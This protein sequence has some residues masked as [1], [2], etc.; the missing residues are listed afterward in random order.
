MKLQEELVIESIGRKGDG[1][2]MAADGSRIFVPRTV[3]GDR[4]KVTVRKTG[5]D[6]LCG[7]LL[8]LIAPGEGRADPP[9]PYFDSCGGCSLQHLKIEEYRRWKLGVIDEILARSGIRPEV[10]LPPVFVPE[11]TRRRATFAAFKQNR[12][13]RLG[14]HRQRSHDIIDVAECM[15][16][17]PAINRFAI[18]SRPFLVRLLTDS[19]PADIFVQEA[20]G[21]LDVMLTGPVGKTHKPALSERETIA[22]MAHELD[23]SRVSWRAKERQAPEV[24]LERR[25]ILKASGALSARLPPGAFLQPSAEGEAALASTVMG[26]LPEG[27][28]L[29]IADLFAGCGTFSGRLLGKG[30]VKA[31]ESDSEACEC[32]RQAGRGLNGF[33]VYKRD[34]FKEPLSSKELDL[35]DAV[36]LDPPRAGAKEQ[37][38][39]IAGSKIKILIYISCNPATFARDAA[40]LA[41]GGYRCA[42]MKVVDQF[43]YSSHAE[44]CGF[45]IKASG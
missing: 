16:L 5:D 24:I 9:C 20:D 13:L 39:A 12:N 2:G 38:R 28:G 10:T 26:F 30:Q 1:I 22:E 35:Y 27:G 8:E 31:F 14:Y 7:E 34:L 21:L 43:I 23:I 15:L 19:R 29:K 6:A 25:P 3:S 45:F 41:E 37:A 32:L 18:R 11:A 33:S 36:V 4:V 42:K 40:T 17:S 44:I